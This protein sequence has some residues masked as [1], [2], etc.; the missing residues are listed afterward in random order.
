MEFAIVDIETTGGYAAANG[1]TEISV[2]V[3]DG[4]R[5]VQQYNTLVNPG[6]NIPYYIR[7]LTGITNEMVAA[8]PPFADIAEQVYALL[9]DRIFVAHSVNFDYSFIR[10]ALA[11]SGYFLDAKK[12]C[13]IRLSR[14]IFPGLPSYSLGNICGQ[15]SIPIVNRHR[16]GGDAEATVKLFQRLMENDTG[17]IIGK[18]LKRNS[19]EQSLPPN[20]PREQFDRLPGSPGVYYFHNQ[21]GKVIYV[22]KAINLKKRVSSHFSNNGT[23][24]QKQDFMRSIYSLTY[25]ECGNELM[26]LVLESHEIK[27]LWPQFNNAQKRFEAVF[28]IFEYCDQRGFKR[29]AI[30]KLRKNMRPLITF[31]DLAEG[32]SLL[33]RYS[34]EFDLCF[35]LTGIATGIEQCQQKNCACQTTHEGEIAAYNVRAESAIGKLRNNNTFVITEKGRTDD[36]VALLVVAEGALQ[37]MG[38]M[39]ATNF[40][41]ENLSL[42]KL[43]DLPPYKENF[44]IRSIIS[45]YLLNNPGRAVYL[46][47]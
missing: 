30:E 8:A 25:Q 4:T 44:N 42:E 16:A 35:R 29:F 40:S 18:F 3:Y 9:K 28:G 39:P 20:L 47:S 12:L 41:T 26:A 22:G 37:R 46:A 7:G 5:V 27:R 45:S 15:L 36:E 43:N 38:Y 13:T 11:E 31:T 24:K 34:E 2:Q 1:I 32:Y 10:A 23:G 17:N 21:K 19:K 6:C 14:K 33:R